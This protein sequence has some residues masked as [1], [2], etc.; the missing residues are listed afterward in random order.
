MRGTKLR[1]ASERD[2]SALVRL[3]NVGFQKDQFTEHQIHYL[4][5]R[6]HAT[7]FVIECDRSDA[8]AAYMLWR[9]SLAHGRLYNIVIDPRFQGRGLGAK[10]LAECEVEAARRGCSR[11]TLE[12]RADN[13]TAIAFYLKYGYKTVDSMANYYEDGTTGY[14]MAKQLTV[15]APEQIRLHIPY[16]AQTLDFTCGP[17]C[18]MMILKRHHP[19]TELTRTMEITLWKEATLVFMTSGTGGTAPLGLAVA[20]RRRG[21]DARVV[22]SSEKVPFLDSVR[23]PHKRE[24]MRLVHED[25]K[26][27]AEQLGVVSVA[28]D[29]AFDDIKSA[30]YR[31]MVPIVLISTYRLT[32][33]RA[34][35]W[36]VVTGFDR[37]NVYIHDPD[38]E[39]YHTDRLRARNLKISQQE[40]Q[41]M[42]RFGKEVFRSAV[43]VGPAAHGRDGRTHRKS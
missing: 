1:L 2:L 41:R 23:V 36:V 32:G 29:F 25:I 11:V 3:E 24:V 4:L 37:E 34:P 13:A 39:S 6:A 16:Y 26:S 5:T 33:D 7:A 20:A 19:T 43:F 22:S 12:V 42:S 40:F 9:R 15:S 38:N 27:A 31:G 35:H 30:M 14:K 28:Y 21:L 10:L 18:L 8:G 17:A